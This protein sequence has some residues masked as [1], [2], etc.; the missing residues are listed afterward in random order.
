MESQVRYLALFLLFLVI[1]SFEW[2]WM[3]SLHKEIQLMLKFFKGPFLVLHFSCCILMTFLMML[4]VILLSAL[5]IRF[6][7]L[8]VIRHLICGNLKWL[9]NLNPI[10]QTLWTGVRSGLFISMLGKLTWFFFDWSNNNGFL[11]VKMDGSVLDEKSSF[12]MLE[13]TF[14][15]K[16][17]LGS[18]IITIAKT[19]SNKNWRSNLFYEIS[20]S[21]GCSVSL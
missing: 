11:D 8:T 14:S 1:D 6:S 16:L 17:D 2:L 15:S 10:Y 19:T 5:M 21:W 12:K 13:L 9:L 3:E 18:Y 20:F 7:I 4:S